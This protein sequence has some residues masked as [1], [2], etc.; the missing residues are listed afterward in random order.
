MPIEVS[1]ALLGIIE[2]KTG[3]KPLKT[4]ACDALWDANSRLFIEK[5]NSPSIKALNTLIQ[6]FITTCEARVTDSSASMFLNTTKAECQ[7]AITDP[8]KYLEQVMAI[9]AGNPR[10]RREPESLTLWPAPPGMTLELQFVLGLV[11]SIYA[12]ALRREISPGEMPGLLPPE[13]IQ[14]MQKTVTAPDT[15]KQYFFEARAE[16]RGIENIQQWVAE[17][18][19][20]ARHDSFTPP[21]PPPT[22]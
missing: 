17:Q 2:S 16:Q 10:L 6:I 11:D 8:S 9:R 15:L 3:R 21:P 18:I 22:Q 7:N 12:Y 13:I 4:D 20:R 5:G 1:E 14:R 19:E